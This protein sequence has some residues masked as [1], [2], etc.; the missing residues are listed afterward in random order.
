MGPP[1]KVY[2]APASKTWKSHTGQTMDQ[3]FVGLTYL[4]IED[5]G[6]VVGVR[7][8]EVKQFILGGD[9]CATPA[10]FDL[11]TG[12]IEFS[13]PFFGCQVEGDDL[14]SD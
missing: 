5:A 2:L 9:A 14:V 3:R 12:G 8:R 11:L 10:N 13:F 6:I 1:G 7:S 4:R